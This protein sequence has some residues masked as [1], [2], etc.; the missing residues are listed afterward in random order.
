MVYRIVVEFRF[1]MNDVNVKYRLRQPLVCVQSDVIGIYSFVYTGAMEK[2]FS[3]QRK[4]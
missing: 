4:L 1:E 3:L 2:P